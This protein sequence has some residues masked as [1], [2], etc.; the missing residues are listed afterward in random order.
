MPERTRCLAPIS[1]MAASEL[2]D[3]L[4]ALEQGD[5]PAAV[6]ALMAIDTASLAAIEQRLAAVG[7]DL[8][9]LLLAASA[10]DSADWAVV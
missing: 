10:G 5:G 6:S 2:R 7:G 8:R 1:L 3:I 9:K 4:T